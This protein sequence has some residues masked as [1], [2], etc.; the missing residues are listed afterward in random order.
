VSE[1]AQDGRYVPSLFV[2]ADR[3]GYVRRQTFS[4]Y[5]KTNEVEDRLRAVI[6]TAVTGLAAAL[7]YGRLLEVFRI[8]RGWLLKGP[9]RLKSLFKFG[10]T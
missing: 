6:V 7:S 10:L 9:C 5:G 8:Y 2:Q 1:S 3:L 4:R